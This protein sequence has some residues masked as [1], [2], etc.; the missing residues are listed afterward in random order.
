MSKAVCTVDPD[1]LLF[2]VSAEWWALSHNRLDLLR[3]VLQKRGHA[4][5]DVVW[6][7]LARSII[8]SYDLGNVSQ[9]DTRDDIDYVFY[10]PFPELRRFVETATED[11]V[12][13][14]LNDM[15]SQNAMLG[16]IWSGNCP[17]ICMSPFL[18][19]LSS[20]DV[21]TKGRARL[22]AILAG[23]AELFRGIV[24]WPITSLEST[25]V[26]FILLASATIQSLLKQD[27]TIL[28]LLRQSTSKLIEFQEKYVI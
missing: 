6:A 15:T 3:D 21:V 16:I 17:F 8:P 5:D 7:L 24:T 13:D 18:Q 2:A 12:L 4:N 1:Q 20:L 27:T 25:E 9:A 23:N 19:R 22:S 14:D 26:E 11:A 28:C 10:D